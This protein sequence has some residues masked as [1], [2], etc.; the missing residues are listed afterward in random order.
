MCASHPFPAPGSKTDLE[1]GAALSPCFGT[2]GPITCVTTEATTGE[3]LMVTRRKQRVRINDRAIDVLL[4][5]R[6]ERREPLMDFL[7][8]LF[9]GER[10]A[11][12]NE[13]FLQRLE[14]WRD[15]LR[16]MVAISLRRG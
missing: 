9:V 12:C 8:F 5:C 14:R 16:R 15:T 2:D 4:E 13:L 7:G 11:A 1:E 10:L 3:L 6:A